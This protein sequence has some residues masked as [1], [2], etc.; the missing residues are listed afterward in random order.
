MHLV[1][2]PGDAHWQ[3]GS[4]VKPVYSEPAFIEEN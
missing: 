4:I 2:E 1:V 3:Q